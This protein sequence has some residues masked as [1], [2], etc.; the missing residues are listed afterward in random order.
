MLGLL[1]LYAAAVVGRAG[2]VRAYTFCLVTARR[3]GGVSYLERVVGLYQEQHVFGRD[4]VGLAVIDVDGWTADR[5]LLTGAGVE[6][7]RLPA[8][9]LAACDGA[10][11]VEGL[12]S[13]RVRQ[14]T[15]DV[16]GALDVCARET[17]GWVILVEDDCEPCP[18]ALSESL[19]I[20]A[21]LS[22]AGSTWMAKFSANMCATA[23]PVPRVSDYSRA[24][25]SRLYTHP[26]DIIFVEGWAPHPQQNLKDS[27]APVVYEHSRN[28][29]H[30]IGNVST[31][32]HKN[33]P[34]WL[35]RYGAMREDTCFT[36]RARSA[37]TRI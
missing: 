19:D 11:D 22:S 31:E 25:L 12:P 13:C 9:K 10:P 14:R 4:G 34:A 16:V 26:H 27:A 2:A 37:A 8:R 30:H 32:E 5:G 3:P 15:L 18:G 36:G 35:A 1:A 7:F 29:W 6:G 21:G 23:F 33:D 17:S 28:L 20:L 24:C